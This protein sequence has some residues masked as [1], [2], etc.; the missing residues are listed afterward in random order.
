MSKESSEE[1]SDAKELWVNIDGKTMVMPAEGS[2]FDTRKRAWERLGVVAEEKLM[3]ESY[4]TWHG[5]AQDDSNCVEPGMEL[6][7]MLRLRGGMVEEDFEFP[8]PQDVTCFIGKKG[9]RLPEVTFKSDLEI[10]DQRLTIQTKESR[11]FGLA[12]A[13]LI[14]GYYVDPTNQFQS[15]GKL[16]IELLDGKEIIVDVTEFTMR[17]NFA[18]KSNHGWHL[19]IRHVTTVQKGE[20]DTDGMQ[21]GDDDDIP[22][23]VSRVTIQKGYYH[24]RLVKQLDSQEMLVEIFYG[25]SVMIRLKVD[26]KVIL[27]ASRFAIN[28]H[29]ETIWDAILGGTGGGDSLGG[30]ITSCDSMDQSYVLKSYV[31]KMAITASFH[32]DPAE[33]V[34]QLCAKKW[35]KNYLSDKLFILIPDEKWPTE[36]ITRLFEPDAPETERKELRVDEPTARTEE[37]EEMPSCSEPNPAEEE[38]EMHSRKSKPERTEEDDRT[39][40][41]KSNG[42]QSETNAEDLKRNR[43]SCGAAEEQT[44]LTNRKTKQKT[45]Q[46]KTKQETKQKKKKRKTKQKKRKTKQKHKTNRKTK[47]KKKKQE[48]RKKKTNRKTKQKKKK[49]KKQK[50]KTNRKTK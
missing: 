26:R 16:S 13:M 23:E 10:E 11:E 50:K 8:T 18:I 2:I 37:K 19:F 12:N 30:N 24:A 27:Y 33:F 35:N 3:Q 44:K 40:C 46:M 14:N 45:K 4:L 28:S 38:D 21:L 6:T 36:R 5:R 43:S 20:C 15:I 1:S 9:S 39:C 25:G 42:A 17:K 7:M 41:P 49:Q 34:K 47:Q 22:I 32:S 48:K 31:T 29:F